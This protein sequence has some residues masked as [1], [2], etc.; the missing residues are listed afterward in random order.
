MLG[1]WVFLRVTTAVENGSSYMGTLLLVAPLLASVL[2]AARRDLERSA[3]ADAFAA[4]RLVRERF[5]YIAMCAI[6]LAALAIGCLRLALLL[7]DVSASTLAQ[8]GVETPSR[9]SGVPASILFGLFFALTVVL[10][11]LTYIVS[12]IALPLVIDGDADFVTSMITSYQAAS[13]NPVPM[14]LWAGIAGL[15]VTIGIATSFT[16]FTLI[17]PLLAYGTWHAYRDLIR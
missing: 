14:L 11:W 10:A 3:N 4:L 7:T 16:G 13:L 17:F 1:S 6:M 12:A 8:V 5:S 2:F 15:L 9:S